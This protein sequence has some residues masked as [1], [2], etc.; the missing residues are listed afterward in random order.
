MHTALPVAGTMLGLPL[1]WDQREGSGSLLPVGKDCSH[2]TYSLNKDT[3]EDCLK[4]KKILTA[5]KC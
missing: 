2:G 1:G 3:T 4:K 5:K